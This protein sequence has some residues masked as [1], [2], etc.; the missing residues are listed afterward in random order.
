MKFKT[1]RNIASVGVICAVGIAGWGAV[2]LFSGGPPSDGRIAIQAPTAP[3]V[4][5]DNPPPAPPAP[6]VAAPSGPPSVEELRTKL[7]SWL[8]VNGD[9]GGLMQRKDIFPNEPYRIN[10][11]RFKEADAAKFSNDPSQ[12]S[13]FRIDLNRDGFDDEKWLLKNGHT[14]KREALDGNGRTVAT[15]YFDK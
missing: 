10:V 12:W 6:P 4:P 8:S 3:T 1:F 13:Q 7:E 5:V 9:R 2:K 14:Y 11:L 15:Q